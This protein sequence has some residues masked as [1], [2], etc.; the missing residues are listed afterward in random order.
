MANTYTLIASNTISSSGTRVVTFTSI[1]ATYTDLL[2][3]VSARSDTAATIVQGYFWIAY[4]AAGTGSSKRL[5][6][7]GSAASSVTFSSGS[8]QVFQ[9]SDIPAASSTSNTFGSIDCYIPN[10]LS[11]NNKSV[12]VDGVTENNA[13]AAY[14]ELTAGLINTTSAITAISFEASSGNL[15][16]NSTF[17]IYGIKNS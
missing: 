10:Y 7:S 11:S 13:T 4:P 9:T 8:Y 14:A 16:N 1:P 3:R 6:G 17:Y 5:I 2:L 12:S 15:V